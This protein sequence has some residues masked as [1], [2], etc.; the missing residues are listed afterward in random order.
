MSLPPN[1]TFMECYRKRTIDSMA[2]S[3]LSQ[4]QTDA[5]WREALKREFKAPMETF[6]R[7]FAQTSRAFSNS[8]NR[9]G[10]LKDELMA[11]EIGGKFAYLTGR[12]STVPATRRAASAR[13]DYSLTQP[14]ASF[15]GYEDRPGSSMRKS[16]RNT[17]LEAR[18]AQIESEVKQAKTHSFKL[19]KELQSLSRTGSR[20]SSARPGA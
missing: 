3:H 6:E 18:L 19:Q 4:N 7:D 8:S 1:T 13:G 20:A 12:M 9:S 5:A 11:S 15:K 14:G 2:N 17:G 10:M 16:S